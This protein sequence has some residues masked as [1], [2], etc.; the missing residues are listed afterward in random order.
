MALRKVHRDLER[1]R[2]FYGAQI[3]AIILNSRPGLTKT[4]KFWDPEELMPHF[5]SV[6][7]TP[8]H[9]PDHGAAGDWRGVKQAMKATTQKAKEKRARRPKPMNHA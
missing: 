6:V 4:S 1:Q 5:K 8:K 3:A 2:S 9:D 7:T